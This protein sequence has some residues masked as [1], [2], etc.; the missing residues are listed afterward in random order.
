MN[1]KLDFKIQI[2]PCVITG[3]FEK[4]IT[5][6]LG[7][8]KF[9]LDSGES[10]A[11]QVDGAFSEQGL[12]MMLH[13]LRAAPLPVPAEVLED[14]AETRAKMN[15]EWV[16]AYRDGTQ[17]KQFPLHGEELHLG[18]VDLHQILEFIIKPKDPTSDLPWFKLDRIIGL[19]RKAD[20]SHAWG[21]MGFPLPD[22]PFHVEYDRK[23]T[24]SFTSG[25]LVGTSA[26]PKQVQ[27]RLGWRVDTLHGD[28]EETKLIIGIE[29]D[30]G[31]WQVVAM[32]PAGSRHLGL[33]QIEARTRI[34]EMVEEI[35]A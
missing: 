28:S 6:T 13:A 11:C 18:N 5:V 22:V 16:A 10:G 30:N 32:E 24:I 9:Q 33:K 31:S 23:V 29:D 4:V 25:P 34:V 3:E 12:E 20:Q 35:E 19:C 17:I 21:R 27:H 1:E 2:A 14:P 7:E 15:Y 8:I 26:Y